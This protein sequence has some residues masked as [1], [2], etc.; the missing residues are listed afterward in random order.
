MLWKNKEIR[1]EYL[2]FL[3]FD[4]GLLIRGYSEPAFVGCT[5]FGNEVD[6]CRGEP[7][8][9][10]FLYFFRCDGMAADI[11]P[12]GESAWSFGVFI[13]GAV[14]SV[15][16]NKNQTS[17][18]GANSDLRMEVYMTLRY[19]GDC[20]E[21]FHFVVGESIEQQCMSGQKCADFF[22]GESPVA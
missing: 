11:S 14:V 1:N 12:Y 21:K 13:V 10:Y 5:V 22:I 2:W 6:F 20:R 8:F 7:T 16:A 4:D 19:A 3:H 18:G 17:A 15:H 9:A